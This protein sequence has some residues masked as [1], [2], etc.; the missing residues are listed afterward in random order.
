[1]IPPAL[2]A[3]IFAIASCVDRSQLYASDP[4][5]HKTPKPW[6]FFEEA[7]QILQRSDD[8]KKMPLANAFT[9]SDTTCQV[10]VILSLQQHGVAEYSRAATLCGLASAMA[11]ELHLHR[12]P[13]G[14]DQIQ[15]QVR[16]RLWWNLYILEK[17]MSTEM[18]RPVLLRA[19]ESDCPYPSPDEADEFELMYIPEERSSGQFGNT[20]IKLRSLSGLHSTI[21][22]CMIMERISREIYSLGARKLIRENQ[23]V[24]E[25]KRI[26]L[27]STL[28]RWEQ[29]MGASPL[30]LELGNDLTSVPASVT[31]YVVRFEVQPEYCG[32]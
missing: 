21:E 12:P 27:W 17:M 28:Q 10:L 29:K 18:G 2:L 9:P 22:L 30:R 25:A 8:G 26:E 14:G 5:D 11:I 19:E 13:E 16:S 15:V 1:M 32:F 24:G 7:L 3:A 6:E 20:P 23:T 4:S 31:N